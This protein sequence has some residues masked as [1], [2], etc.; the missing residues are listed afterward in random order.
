[1]TSKTPLP[2]RRL[3]LA[4]SLLL[5]GAAALLLAGPA[6]ASR[7][8][9]V[10]VVGPTTATD[11]ATLT[12]NLTTS[13][14]GTGAGS[15]SETQL[16]VNGNATGALHDFGNLAD[17]ENHSALENVTLACGIYTVNATVDPA[18][19]VPE[20]NETNNNATLTL[21]VT[22][23]ANFTAVQSGVA[24]SITVTL[25]ASSSHGC[26]P[27]NYTWNVGG[28]TFYGANIS[29]TPPAGNLTVELA[30]RG[31]NNS[32]LTGRVTRVLVIPNAAPSVSLSLADDTIPTGWPLG[33]SVTADDTDGTVAS[34]WIDFG[35][36][37]TSTSPVTASTYEYHRGGNF[38][39]TVRVT[40]NLNVTS[41]ST[42]L[43]HVS[44]RAAT[45]VTSFPYWETEAG[46]PIE[47]NASGSTDPDG[48]PLDITWDFGDG[49]T[50][51]GPVVNHTYDTPGTYMAKVRVTDAGGDTTEQTMQIRI[52]PK[53]S[54]GSA[55][56]LWILILAV[57]A[58]LAIMILRRRRDDEKAETPP[59][60]D[61]PTAPGE[62]PGAP[63][64][65]PSGE[66]SSSKPPSP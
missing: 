61:K 56:W 16:Y 5:A 13:N 20:N 62:T 64:D 49:T 15:T 51:S 40:D 53:P 11:N 66:G 46:T 22:P 14:S 21:V 25:D 3:T 32:L 29:Y 19:Q 28:V 48:E 50:G 65:K 44:N 4:A 30:V 7:D 52:D 10:T 63:G 42:V 55:W 45:I 34:T 35:D 41:E 37:N 1:M 38:T 12:Y 36:G 57:L 6:L 17:G 60:T 23:F 26:A 27:L 58:L 18:D 43:V 39:V 33:L 31:G 8:L 2:A 59:P 9:T 54:G 47:F 24:G